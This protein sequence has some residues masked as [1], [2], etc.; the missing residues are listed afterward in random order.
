MPVPTAEE[1]LEQSVEALQSSAVTVK[2]AD[3]VVTYKDAAEIAGS[4]RVVGQAQQGPQ[5]RVVVRPKAPKL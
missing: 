5:M 3:K 2:D 4:I 1:L